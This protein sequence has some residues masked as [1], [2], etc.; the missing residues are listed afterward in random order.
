NGG[1]GE[2]CASW[3]LQNGYAKPFKIMG[4][5]DEYTVTGSQVEILNHYGISKE[6]IAKEVTGLLK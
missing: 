3:L 2:A 1:L 5:P 6:G 4:I